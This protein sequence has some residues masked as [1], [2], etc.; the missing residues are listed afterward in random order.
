MEKTFVVI[1]REDRLPTG[2]KG[3]YTL[4]TRKVFTEE[5]EAFLYLD[6]I[7]PSREPIVVPGDFAHL[8]FPEAPLPKPA[9]D[10]EAVEELGRVAKALG[11]DR[12]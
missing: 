2:E 7:S 8:R 5:R 1:A 6:G 9:L 10:P 12:G 4:A 11:Y 3:R